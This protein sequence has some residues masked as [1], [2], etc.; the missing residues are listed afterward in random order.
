[1]TH[2]P[3]SIDDILASGT[4]TAMP[5]AAPPDGVAL[6]DRFQAY[7]N[8]FKVFPIKPGERV[9]FLTDPRLDRRV[10]EAIS[11][12]ARIISS[13]PLFG[14]SSPKVSITL[15]PANPSFTFIFS[16]D[17]SGR[18]GIPWGMSFTFSGGAP[19]TSC[20]IC[21]ALWLMTT[22]YCEQS[23]NSSRTCF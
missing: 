7:A 22:R 13:T 18:S 10:V 12:I 1:M 23:A 4:A 9:A 8:M 11:G 15:W 6:R 3:P 20:K 21:S 2:N 17:C 14:F 19:Y 5:P 16:G